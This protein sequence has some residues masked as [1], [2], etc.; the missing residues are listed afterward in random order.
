MLS[1]EFNRLYRRNEPINLKYQINNF[2]SNFT[3]FELFLFSFQLIGKIF[4]RFS[5]LFDLK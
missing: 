1:K 5:S 3:L 2:Y 4:K